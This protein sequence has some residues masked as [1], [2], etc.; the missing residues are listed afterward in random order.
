MKPVFTI[1]VYQK[2]EKE[3]F[4]LLISNNIEIFCDVRQRRGMRGNLY[5]FVNSKYLQH[6]LS[7]FNIKYYHLKELS[8]SKEIRNSQKK[9]DL[10][11]GIKKRERNKLTDSFIHSYEEKVLSNFNFDFFIHELSIGEKR[12]AL[13]CVEK[14]Y[15]ACHR[16]LIAERLNQIFLEIKIIHL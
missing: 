15:M 2:S 4:D 9:D 16:S 8:P 12:L 11:L 3:F 13:F 6:K 10:K 7:D 1:G 5:K 14:D